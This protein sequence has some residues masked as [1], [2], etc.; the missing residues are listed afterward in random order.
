MVFGLFLLRNLPKDAIF[1]NEE[2]EWWR[3]E[4]GFLRRSSSICKLLT[5]GSHLRVL[6]SDTLE[7]CFLA[8]SVQIGGRS[9]EICVFVYSHLK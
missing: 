2:L 6:D 8:C 4:L 3:M 5:V 1:T 9:V 7:Q